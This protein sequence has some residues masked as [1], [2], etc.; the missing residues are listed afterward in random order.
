[1]KTR[2][3]GKVYKK[4]MRRLVALFAIIGVITTL[5]GI[6]P[7]EEAKA[8]IGH[9]IALQPMPTAS[10]KG[11]IKEEIMQQSIKYGVDYKT[12]LRI[13]ECESSLNPMAK[14]KVSTAK[15]LY[16]FTDPTWEYIG[17]EGD[18][19]NMKE[20]IRLFMVYYPKH[21]QWWQCK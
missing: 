13:A 9:P 3:Y 15:G 4:E 5:V 21:P 19:Y 2:T 11:R 10:I 16:Q 12:A 1:M 18:Q 20:N 7:K 8:F 17:G 14:H 6:Y